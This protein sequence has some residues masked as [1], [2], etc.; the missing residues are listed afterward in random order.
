MVHVYIHYPTLQIARKISRLLLKKRL[1]G[2]ISF[3]KQDD[4]YWWQGKMVATKGI[5]TFVA[6]PKKNY[7]AIE[8]LVKKHHP[9]QVPCIL[10]LPINRVL[11]SYAR[12]LTK[13]TK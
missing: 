6:A 1:A 3:V 11:K 12:W 7:P 4:M 2:C 5:V 13:E 8:K 9:Y 10:E